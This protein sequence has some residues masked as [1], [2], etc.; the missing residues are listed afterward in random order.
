V[1]AT[2]W[3]WLITRDELEGWILHQSSDLLV[4]NKPAGIVCHPSRHG[5][6]SS[7]VGA[8]REYLSARTLHMPF[9]LDRE[10]SGVLLLAASLATGRRLQAAVL[11]RSFRKTYVAILG[12]E[13]GASVTVEQPV[14]RNPDSEFF[15]RQAVVAGGQPAC[16]VFI[17]KEVRSGYTLAEVHPHTGRR[18]QIR[19]HAAFLGHP[20][21]GDK[22]YGQD[23]GAMLECIRNGF[24]SEALAKL[25][26]QRHALHASEVVF[27]TEAGDESFSAP[28]APDMLAFWDGLRQRGR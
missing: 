14:G 24:S 20:I 9:R 1:P 27:A 16:T 15:S 19:V 17:P 18:H 28:L 4:L 11:R 13:L 25:P 26:M 6:W 8:C 22:L 5:P 12:G 23:P 21:L 10:T 3:G 7:L 2:E